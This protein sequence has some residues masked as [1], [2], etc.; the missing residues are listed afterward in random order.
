MW[1]KSTAGQGG[2][3]TRYRWT[4]GRVRSWG[5]PGHGK[6]FHYLVPNCSKKA[7]KKKKKLT[8]LNVTL[9]VCED[10]SVCSWGQDGV[11]GVIELEGKG[12]I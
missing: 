12:W 5:L 4:G 8:S 2:T 9:A 11:G 10:G 7:M 6:G 1:V 3:G